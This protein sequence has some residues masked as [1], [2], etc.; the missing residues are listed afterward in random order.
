MPPNL[1]FVKKGWKHRSGLSYHSIWLTRCQLHCHT[2]CAIKPPT[3]QLVQCFFFRFYTGFTNWIIF[4]CFTIITRSTIYSLSSPFLNVSHLPCH[5]ND[6]KYWGS[7]K[8]PSTTFISQSPLNTGFSNLEYHVMR[9]YCA[10]TGQI[11]RTFLC[12]IPVKR[13]SFFPPLPI[14]QE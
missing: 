11:L 7:I 5:Q 8:T 10:N 6:I 2:H 12:T 14:N 1:V 4:A 13:C 9:K 3:T